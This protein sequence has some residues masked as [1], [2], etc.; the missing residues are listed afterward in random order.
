MPTFR[1]GCPDGHET[2][3]WIHPT[4]SDKKPPATVDCD[5]CGA[6]STRLP[7]TRYATHLVS[8]ADQKS[9]WTKPGWSGVDYRNGPAGRPATH[10]RG[11]DGHSSAYAD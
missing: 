11:L 9:G 2:E 10:L 5:T 4:A 3:H 8:N 6:S 7:P 1:Y